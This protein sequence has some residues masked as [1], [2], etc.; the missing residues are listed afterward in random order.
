MKKRPWGF[1]HPQLILAMPL[2]IENDK[3]IKIQQ[4]KTK[5]KLMIRKFRDILIAYDFLFFLHT[6]LITNAF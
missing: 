3:T 4:N 5:I 2:I 6:N 1:G